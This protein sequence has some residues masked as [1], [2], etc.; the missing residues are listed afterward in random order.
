MST[1][2]SSGIDP[3]VPPSGEGCADCD[4]AGGWW[5]HLRRCAACGHIGCCDSSPAQHAGAHAAAT[6]HPVIRTYE[7]G[8]SWFWNYSTESYVEDGPELAPPLSHP[9]A[10]PTPGP[11]DRVPRDWQA[12]LH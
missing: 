10:Q 11:A 6:G 1:P 8:E 9:T 2:Q 5:F 4:K 12:H 3:T 7:P